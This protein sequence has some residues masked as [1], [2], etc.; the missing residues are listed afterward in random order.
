MAVIK[1]PSKPTKKVKLS[2]NIDMM[3]LFE[4]GIDTDAF[5]REMIQ[6]FKQIYPQAENVVIE[7]SQG[8][9]F[10][11]PTATYSVTGTV[12]LV[13]PDGIKEIEP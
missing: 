11:E 12:P 7:A 10:L 3:E 9:S 6:R 5:V 13:S 8:E 4:S 2:E 1:E